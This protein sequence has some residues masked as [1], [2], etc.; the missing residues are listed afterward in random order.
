LIDD[1]GYN[2]A[3]SGINV[4]EGHQCIFSYNGTELFRGIIMTQK[5][6]HKKRMIITAYDNGI[7][8]ANNKDTFAYE[9]K[10]ASDIFKDCCTRFGLP[11]GE[12]A[13]CTYKI[14]E[15]TKSSTTA[16][17]AI[18]D[19][20]SLD[21]DNTGIRHYVLSEKGK[22]KL[23]TRREN[24]LQWVIEIGQNLINY[25]YTKSIEDIKTRIK[26]LS[27]E[28]TVLAEK[29]NT[30]LEKKIGVF[31]DINKPDEGLTSAQ[32]TQLADTL[33]EA[34]STPERSL[35]I[36]A[37]GIP[38]VTSGIGVF[39]IIKALGLSKTFYV[40]ED[41]HIFS[42]RSHTMSLKLNYAND[43]GKT[44]PA[45]T[46]AEEQKSYAVGDVVNFTGA[47]HYVSS[48]ATSPTGTKCAAGPA[49]ITLIA[50]GAK[51]PYHLIH[52]T[53]ASRVYGWVDEGTFSK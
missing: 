30:A 40:D 2:H 44:T 46:K 17:D 36:E 14:P 4:E 37:V 42:D 1:D 33:L 53:S 21:F 16:F 23:L 22:I 51:H 28:N 29:K 26:L 15:L 24:I 31:Q 49:K 45:E 43:L 39:I 9:N 11:M 32:L 7:Y 12:V 38:A 5:Q 35:E 6:S 25:S 47:Y 8:L 19:A 34:E 3:R 41:T 20:L 27:R 52:T 48:N 50:K 18:C 13:N 10:T